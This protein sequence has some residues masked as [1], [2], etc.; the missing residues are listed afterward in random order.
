MLFFLPRSPWWVGCWLPG[1]CLGWTIWQSGKVPG[2]IRE[3]LASVVE[4]LAIVEDAAEP[5]SRQTI[6]RWSSAWRTGR[7]PT[8]MA[9]E[10]PWIGVGFGNYEVALS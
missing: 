4:E 6:T 3:R 10:H 5:N 7:R 2:A 1:A 9:E 8:Q